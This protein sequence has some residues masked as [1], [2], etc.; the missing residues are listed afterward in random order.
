FART[1]TE[2]NS[3]QPVSQGSAASRCLQTI[4]KPWGGTKLPFT[5]PRRR[6]ASHSV[7]RFPLVC[8]I[9]AADSRPFRR[10]GQGTPGW[11]KVS[12]TLRLLLHAP[13]AAKVAP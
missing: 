6:K 5:P 8:A 4:G 2:T 11:D 12:S 7:R 13:C 3:A 1:V 10:K 9:E